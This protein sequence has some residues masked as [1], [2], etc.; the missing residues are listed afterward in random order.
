LA[1]IPDQIEIELKRAVDDQG[2][3]EIRIRCDGRKCFFVSGRRTVQ[4]SNSRGT[5]EFVIVDG[6]PIS[7]VETPLVQKPVTEIGRIV[8]KD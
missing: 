3:D 1:A 6:A 5:S 4:F 8:V 2:L 7:G